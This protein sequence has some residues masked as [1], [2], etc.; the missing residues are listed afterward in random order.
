MAKVDLGMNL[1]DF[2]K[3]AMSQEKPLDFI[4]L[5][6]AFELIHKT[7]NN[8]FY[9]GIEPF[10]KNR[11]WMLLCNERHDYTV[12]RFEVDFDNKKFLKD[13]QE[14]LFNRG[15]ILSIELK[16]EGN[17]EIWI[18]DELTN[19]NFVY[20]FFNYTDAVIEEK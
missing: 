3:Q 8:K 16:N 7:L 12:F 5:N 9:G 10:N 4:M 17:F 14:C 15:A 6:K 2:N 19:E 1:Y 18:R 20:Y 13:L 11:Y